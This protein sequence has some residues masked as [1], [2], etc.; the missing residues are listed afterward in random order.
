MAVTLC[1]NGK[2]VPIR[3]GEVCPVC[4]SKKGRCSAFYEND[5]ELAFYR[6]KYKESHRSSNGWYI[7][8]AYEVHGA[9]PDGC[10]SRQTLPDVEVGE[11]MKR[12]EN[13]SLIL[14]I[15]ICGSLYANTKVLI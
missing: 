15:G 4:G 9:R 3:S 7:H 6:C 12:R 2:F 8:T 5:G 13:G 10:D 11:E 14:R 1:E